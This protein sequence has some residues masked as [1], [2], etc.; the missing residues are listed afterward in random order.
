[1]GRGRGGRRRRGELVQPGAHGEPD[2]R[3]G[4]ALVEGY[5]GAGGVLQGHSPTVLAGSLSAVASWLELNV[6]RSLS[7]A[8]DQ[9]LRWQAEAEL[10][11]ALVEL[12]RR[13]ARVDRWIE[14][15]G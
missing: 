2:E 13:L 6:R 11:G 5:C 4:L 8:A 9:A 12:A 7:Q 3:V 14:L 1:V 10:T 15:L